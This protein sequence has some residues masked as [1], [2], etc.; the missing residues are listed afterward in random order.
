M[1][2]CAYVRQ[3]QRA[4]ERE[5]GRERER[6]SQMLVPRVK[7]TIY[8]GLEGALVP[9]FNKGADLMRSETRWAKRREKV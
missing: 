2:E 5:R 8:G 3:R 4:G 6:P 7:A 1:C 9:S